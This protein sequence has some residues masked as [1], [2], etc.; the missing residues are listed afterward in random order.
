LK[1]PRFFF[2]FCTGTML[3]LSFGCNDAPD[4]V[5]ATTQPVG[6]LGALQ[7]DTFYATGHSS[8]PN[9]LY[10]SSIDRFM[11]GK[12]Q[13]YQAWACLKFG[14]WP[15]SMIGVTITSATI[16][17]KSVYHFG[18]SMSVLPF[19]AYRA[20][21]SWAGDSLTYDSLSLNTVGQSPYNCY[22]DIS[23]KYSSTIQ[24]GDTDWVTIDIP[25]TTM[26]REWFSTNSDT[27]QL[28]DGIILSPD[29]SFSN[30]IRGFYSYYASDTSYQP[31]LYVNYDGAYG[32]NTYVHKVSSSKYV[33]SID[34]AS[35]IT[36]NNLIYIQ[37]GISYRGLISFD[38]ILTTWPVSI[39]RA[40]LQVTLDESKSSPQFNFFPTPFLHDSV[41]ALS[42]GTDSIS[43]GSFSALS[44]RSTDNF[45]RV[46]YSFESAGLAN[47]WL[48]N[49]SARKVAL[50]GYFESSSFDLFTMYSENAEKKLRPRII[51]T[52]SIKR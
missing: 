15:D 52:Y 16:R 21:A 29:P 40:L 3:C 36:D 47:R 23:T 20:R 45:G 6:Y 19:D 7:V 38:S 17:L 31:T 49:S 10:T 4:S 22:Y 11:L 12:Y 32:P 8:L 35:L 24:A 25:D 48:N 18:K 9:R 27:M 34:R 50:C 13:T 42:V 14:S 5:G 43:D 51:I 39:H 44:Q 37:S 30:V 46:I 26:L 41:Y 33:S 28:N 1:S 2:L